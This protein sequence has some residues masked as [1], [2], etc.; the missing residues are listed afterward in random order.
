[1]RLIQKD[2]SFDWRRMTYSG[3]HEAAFFQMNERRGKT[4]LPHALTGFAAIESAA[5]RQIAWNGLHT[6]ARDN[7]G[8]IQSAR[9]FR[10][11][12][13]GLRTRHNAKELLT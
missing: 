10:P 5:K 6:R 1:M 7:A 8:R 9:A 2:D 12:T 11:R 3:Q 13:G 4:P